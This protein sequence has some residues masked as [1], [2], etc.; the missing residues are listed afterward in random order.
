MDDLE[1]C[2]FATVPSLIPGEVGFSLAVADSVMGTF[3]MPEVYQTTY[4]DFA[5][6]IKVRVEETAGFADQTWGDFVFVR[7]GAGPKGYH[8]F[9][10]H[11][12]RTPA[13][14][15]RAVPSR[16]YPDNQPYEW[17]NVII[18][19]GATEDLGAPLS[20][21]A[22][23]QVV[24]LARLTEE[25]YLVPEQVLPTDIDVTFYVSLK[26]FPRRMTRTT[27][28]AQRLVNYAE[29]NI[30][31]SVMCLHPYMEFPI[32]QTSATKLRGWGTTRSRSPMGNRT[33]RQY[34]ATKQTGWQR[35]IKSTTTTFDE[36]SGMWG[37]KV[38]TVRVPDGWEVIRD[39]SN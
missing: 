8:L 10:F 17:P 9:Y 5:C 26:P 35:H 11:K 4:R 34:K 29:R 39:I 19:L 16:S 3:A 23:G 15:S 24:N 20:F 37:L 31:G 18:Y 7:N 14:V 12:N 25:L 27:K 36:E 13:E 2:I 1:P 21:E 33:R 38:E 28:P 30:R 6:P 22:N 32:V